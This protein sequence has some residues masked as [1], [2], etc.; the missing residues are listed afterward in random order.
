MLGATPSLP[1]L[2][3]DQNRSPGDTLADK[4]RARA[5][6]LAELGVT[7]ADS[8]LFTALHYGFTIPPTHF[9]WRAAQ[10]DYNP[11]GPTATEEECRLALA[12]CLARGWLQV[13]DGPAR[14]SIADNLRKERVLGPI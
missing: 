4:Q 14:A 2:L 11:D 6:G 10:E 1:F 3:T 12:N 5:E 13:I 9:P 8:A 7:P